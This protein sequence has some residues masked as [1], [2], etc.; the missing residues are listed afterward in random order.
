MKR[1]G[2]ATAVAPYSTRARPGAPVA[3]PLDWREA[4]PVLDPRQFTVE[5]MPRRLARMP[6]DPWT[7]LLNSQQSIGKAAL[8][9]MKVG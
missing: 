7:P 9:T 2:G 8:K 3:T 6:D 5:T 1:S 4:M